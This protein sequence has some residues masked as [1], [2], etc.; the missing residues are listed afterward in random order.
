MVHGSGGRAGSARIVAATVMLC[1]LPWSAVIPADAAATPGGAAGPAVEASRARL[2]I[3]PARVLAGDPVAVKVSGLDPGALATIHVQSVTTDDAGSIQPLYAEATYMADSSGRIDLATSG[4]VTGNYEGADAR[5]LFW[6]QRPLASDPLGQRALAALPLADT[7]SVVGRDVLTLEVGGAVADR[8]VVTFVPADSGV[9]REAVRSGGLVGVFYSLRGAKHRPVVVALS[10][11]EGGLDVAEW[12]GPR[13]ASRGFVVFGLGYFSPPGSAIDG[14]P[15]ALARIPVELL[16]RARAWLATRTEADVHHLGVVG[17]SKGAEFALVLASI[18][19]WI[20]AAVAYAPSDVI[21]QG[22]EFGEAAKPASSWT[23]AGKELPFLPT[24]GT[25]E[26]I[27]KCR[28]SGGKVELARI[29]RA[30]RAAAS[31]AAVEAATIAVERSHAA[32]LLIGGGDDRLGD[33]GASAQRTAA[34]LHHA[35]YPHPHE[36]LVYP[37]AGHDLLGT[38]WQPVSVDSTDLFDAGGTPEADARAQGDSW[39]RVLNFL[40]RQLIPSGPTRPGQHR[41]PQRE[42]NR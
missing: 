22:I 35:V 32:L 39:P 13:L 36:V 28:Q 6:S 25:R 24:T 40:E 18:Y 26:A 3:F 31:P 29:A 5:G 14:L 16:E 20:E 4:P 23:R 37:R 8:G 19:D 7:S 27:A 10:G 12:L 33:S 17:Y 30:S 1:T 38:G 11:S 42:R 34:R 41:T 21:G 15:T 9:V 2:E